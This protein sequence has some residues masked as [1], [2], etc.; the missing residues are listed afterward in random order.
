MGWLL[1]NCCTFEEPLALLKS[2]GNFN[3]WSNKPKLP[4]K[5]SDDLNSLFEE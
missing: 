5:F 2:V 3:F 1:Y 4:K